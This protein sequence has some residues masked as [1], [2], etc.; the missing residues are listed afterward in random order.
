MARRSTTKKATRKSTVKKATRK[1][2]AKKAARKN[3]TKAVAKKATRK[4]SA[5]KQTRNPVATATA[6]HL[7]A[8]K[9]LASAKKVY[10]RAVIVEARAAEKLKA[11]TEKLAAKALKK[12]GANGGTAS[13]DA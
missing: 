4:V 11:A 1:A 12:K 9:K 13:D 8:E 5:R 3:A 6:A 2:P 7:V 10:D